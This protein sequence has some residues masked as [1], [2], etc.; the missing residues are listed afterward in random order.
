MITVAKPHSIPTSG[1]EPAFDTIEVLFKEARRRERR[2]RFKW[3]GSA[4]AVLMI[5]GVVTGASINAFGSSTSPSTTAKLSAAT[6][7]KAGI[8][9]CQG[10]SVVEPRSFVITCADA[11]SELTKT[12]WSTWTSTGA[13]G[14]TTF[15]MNL[16]TPYCAAS[17]MSYFPN[18]HV[19]LSAPVATKHGKLFSLM[20][21]RYMLHAHAKTYRFSWKGDPSF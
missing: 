19:T 17:P 11:N 14:T 1:E 20:T 10:I 9:T 15:A 18:S 3:L 4:L 16:C 12:H 13:S 21:V 5:V 7:T 2:R 6:S 8:I